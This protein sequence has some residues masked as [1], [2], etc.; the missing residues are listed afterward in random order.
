MDED[1]KGHHIHNTA[2]PILESGRWIPH[3]V[4]IRP[5]FRYADGSTQAL[6]KYRRAKGHGGT[7]YGER[8]WKGYRRQC[9]PWGGG[10]FDKTEDDLMNALYPFQKSPRCS[11]TSK[12]TQK[13]CQAPAVTGWTVCRF[14]GA[15]GGGPK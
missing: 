3:I 6:P 2:S 11:A 10:C 1:Y 4:Q 5:D 7:H 8:W 15:R 12:R 14:H 13:P 9:N